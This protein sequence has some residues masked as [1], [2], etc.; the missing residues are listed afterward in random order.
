MAGL[1][2]I[3]SKA[4]WAVGLGLAGAVGA[5][6]FVKTESGQPIF[7]ALVEKIRGASDTVD[8]E[9]TSKI[10]LMDKSA[11]KT[12]DIVKSTEET[13]KIESEGTGPKM[14]N[15]KIAHPKIEMPKIAMSNLDAQ[16]GTKPEPSNI[17]KSIAKVGEAKKETTNKPQ[18][19]SALENSDAKPKMTPT[20]AVENKITDDA[21][22]MAMAMK[23]MPPSIDLLRVARDGYVVMAGRA[24]PNSNVFA[25]NGSEIIG[26]TKSN[27]M[28]DYVFVFDYPLEIG[29]HELIVTAGNDKSNMV[30]SLSAGVVILPENKSDMIVLLSKPGEASKIIQM[31]SRRFGPKTVNLK[32]NAKADNKAKEVAKLPIAINAVD[33]EEK[34][35]YIAGAATPNST[36][37]VYIDNDFKGK[38][39]TG[40]E[41]AFLYY[42]RES[43]TVG[44]HALRV[45][46]LGP[47]NAT[48]IARAEVVL[49]H[50]TKQS[51]AI[52]FAN[53]ATNKMA[54]K[55]AVDKRFTKVEAVEAVEE[56]AKTQVTKIAEMPAKKSTTKK[57]GSVANAAIPS[58][59]TGKKIADIGDVPAKKMTIDVSD[60][61]G[62]SDTKTS[63]G[64]RVIKS[65]S[66]VIIRR[67][68]SLWKVSRRK[69]GTGSKYTIIY[70][71]NRDQVKNPHRI[72]PG[73]VLN[74]PEDVQISQ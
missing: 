10:D 70:A 40:E 6:T 20:I 1:I 2:A 16:Q 42:G 34:R 21:K 13:S 19:M 38:A 23:S 54:D 32:G 61:S 24:E 46:M 45:D 9:Q 67:G 39:I 3:N 49:D 41:G 57:S 43:I 59:S 62:A 15:P 37:N 36:V 63:D 48:V 44:K 27:A 56:K 28:G 5:A 74:I 69:F 33:V 7:V 4:I 53:K 55:K 22:E 35:Y 18:V 26:K 29:E 25:F 47:D 17:E 8:S 51:K 50:E 65:G 58:G 73:Q 14:V 31:P 64:K 30:S 71:A 12:K 60:V 72:Y 66:S 52:A 11:A 68:D